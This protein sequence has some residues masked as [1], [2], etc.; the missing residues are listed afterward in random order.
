MGEDGLPAPPG[1][2][3]GEY[4]DALRSALA[5]AKRLREALDAIEEWRAAA[6]VTQAEE[7]IE[8][9]IAH[10]MPPDA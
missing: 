6:Y 8:A 7:R 9:L 4:A 5:D 2:P 10:C 3:L 1:G